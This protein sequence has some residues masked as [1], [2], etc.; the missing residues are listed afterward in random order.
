MTNA[1]VLGL[2]ED[3]ITYLEGEDPP[4]E[5]VITRLKQ[6]RTAANKNEIV[7]N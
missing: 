4:K 2:L 6:I 3:P 1:D 5:S 7:Q